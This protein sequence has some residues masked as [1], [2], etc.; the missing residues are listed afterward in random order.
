M[1]LESLDVLMSKGFLTALNSASSSAV[2]D[3]RKQFPQPEIPEWKFPHHV[4]RLAFSFRAVISPRS[5]KRR[6]GQGG[7]VERE[8]L[9]WFSSMA[10]MKLSCVYQKLLALPA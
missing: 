4:P 6:S 2:T 10:G 8:T 7:N 3:S 5:L 9:F 1:S